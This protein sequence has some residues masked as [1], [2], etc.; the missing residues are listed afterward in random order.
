MAEDSAPTA[1]GDQWL[2]RWRGTGRHLSVRRLAVSSAGGAGS[3]MAGKLAKSEKR[4]AR[5]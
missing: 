5:H 2:S 4:L 1:E 3:P